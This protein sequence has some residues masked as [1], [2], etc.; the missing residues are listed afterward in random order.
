MEKIKNIVKSFG[1]LHLRAIEKG[2]SFWD[3]VFWF[4]C[5]VAIIYAIYAGMVYL[6]AWQ[7]MFTII[8]IILR[9]VIDGKICDRT[10][11]WNKRL[12][13]KGTYKFGWL[14][15]VVVFVFLLINVRF[16][17]FCDIRVYDTETKSYSQMSAVEYVPNNGRYHLVWAGT[18]FR[19][20][21]K[22]T[23][24][25]EKYVYTIMYSLKVNELTDNSLSMIKARIDSGKETES[26]LEGNIGVEEILPAADKFLAKKSAEEI[27]APSFGREVEYFLQEVYRAKGYEFKEFQVETKSITRKPVL[28]NPAE[29]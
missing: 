20:A 1:A 18:Q 13:N 16:A 3:V 19:S 10:E 12:T 7:L 28:P 15:A 17:V 11:D 26:Y 14:A 9:I 29:T 24:E 22:L 5:F 25:K 27:L 6:S 4:T 23:V 2:E 8:F 21:V